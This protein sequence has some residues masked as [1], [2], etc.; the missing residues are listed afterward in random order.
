MVWKA[1]KLMLSKLWSMVSKLWTLWGD[2]LESHELFEGKV[3]KP[4][5]NFMCISKSYE[6]LLRYVDKIWTMLS[7]L[8]SM[9]SKIWSMASKLWTFW[10]DGLESYE[11]S[12][13]VV[14]KDMKFLKGWFGKI[15]SMVSKLWT[16]QGGGLGSY[17]HFTWYF[18]R[19]DWW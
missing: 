8:W 11:L 3:W 14:W 4:M 7:K 1:M 18:G 17:E 12:E 19:Y 2:G 16:F 6:R 15:W 13:G 9:V 5:N 10:G